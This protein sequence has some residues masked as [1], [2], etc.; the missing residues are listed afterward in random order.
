[1]CLYCQH[2]KAL[3]D[4]GFVAAI[5][6]QDIVGGPCIEISDSGG[7]GINYCPM[8]GRKLETDDT[9]DTLQTPCD[10]C[11]YNPPSS[12]DGK[13][14]SVCPASAVYRDGEAEP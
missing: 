6:H 4:H 3:F 2:G 9:N 1:M 11:K 5:G 10:L 7:F 14:C 12:C 8:C 13:P